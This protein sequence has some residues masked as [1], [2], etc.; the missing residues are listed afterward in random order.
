MPNPSVE[1]VV[2]IARKLMR[3]ESG[4]D[5][6]VIGDTF[7][8]QA[9]AQADREALRA[10]RKGGGNTPV[11]RALEDGFTIPSETAINDAAGTT[12]ST[13]TMTVDSTTGYDASGAAVIWDGD[14]PDI[15]FYTGV[16][17]TSFTGVT[18]LAF[19]HEDNDLI[20]PLLALPSN[21]GKFRRSEEH[22]DGVQLNGNPL[23]FIDG[24]PT[25]G[26]FSIRDDGTTKYL[27][28]PKGSTGDVSIWFDKDSNTIDSVDDLISLP[29]DW[30]FFYAWRCIELALFGRGDY[31][32]IALAKQ[33]GDMEKLDLLKDRNVGRMI[34][35]RKYS[36]FG[37]RSSLAYRE[38]AL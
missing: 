6:P 35:V 2:E 34:R 18:G 25:P 10:Y 23:G 32:I 27:W 33:K 7:M 3:E 8:V 12:T 24:V 38:N 37:E 5:L 15:F 22:G 20:Q 17:A 36:Q 29:D 1:T 31:S 9:V 11:D 26:K 19:D 14:M 28:L 21:V 30:Q 4:S 16:T 13:V